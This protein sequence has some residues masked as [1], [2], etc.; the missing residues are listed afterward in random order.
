MIYKS[1]DDLIR[2]LYSLTHHKYSY[3]EL[4]SLIKLFFKIIYD[5]LYKSFDDKNSSSVEIPYLGT[6]SISPSGESSID[7]DDVSFKIIDSSIFGEDVLEEEFEETIDFLILKIR[8]SIF[9]HLKINEE[10]D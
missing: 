3:D 6:L 8:R 10:G 2:K 9:E 7:I 4:D 1:K 5:Q